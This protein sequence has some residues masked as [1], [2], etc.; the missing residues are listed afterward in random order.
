MKVAIFGLG[1]I[2]TIL[3]FVAGIIYTS[4]RIA[5]I[6]VIFSAIVAYTLSFCLYWQN[7]ILT[8]PKLFKPTFSE[9]INN[10]TFSLGE[11]GISVGYSKNKLESKHIKNAFVLN[12]FHPVE[13][14]IENDQLYADVT[15]YGGNGFPPIEIKKNQISNKPD[16]W[17]L[18]SNKNALEIVDKNQVPIYQFFYKNPSHI[19]MNG[20]FPFP[21]GLIL[22]SQNGVN[23][24]PKLPAS[25]KLKRIFKYPSWKYPGRIFKNSF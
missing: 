15:I 24:N 13:L 11:K 16:D 9:K 4:H 6:W 21:G 10:F 5:A 23:I 7:D 19:V 3:L 14:Y 2:A 18:N 22:A 8:K 20:I 25:F 17:D 12:D 1:I